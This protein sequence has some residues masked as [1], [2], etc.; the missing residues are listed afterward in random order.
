MRESD[1]GVLSSRTEHV[2]FCAMYQ[3]PMEARR[4]VELSGL[5]VV[6]QMSGVKQIVPE[7]RV[8]EAIDWRRGTLSRLFTVYG[9]AEDHDRLYDQYQQIQRSIVARYEMAERSN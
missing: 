7:C 6:D 2:A 1:G 4:L 8:G 9:V 5:D 3:A